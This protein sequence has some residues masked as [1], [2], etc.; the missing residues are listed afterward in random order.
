MRSE[1][2]IP[3]EILEEEDLP[4]EAIAQFIGT[5]G[6]R[7]L[8]DN[9]EWELTHFDEQGVIPGKLVKGGPARPDFR[10]HCFITATTPGK[11]VMVEGE[12][13]KAFRRRTMK[14]V[15][16]AEG[17]SHIIDNVLIVRH[18]ETYIH[19]FANFVYVTDSALDV[20]VLK[21]LIFRE[22]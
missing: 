18:G 6:F 19:F 2:E 20:P 11:I 3:E 1:P 10:Q 12:D 16:L 8:T 22:G 7:H 15:P 21:K 5:Y 9:T 4:R 13:T 17:E 14:M